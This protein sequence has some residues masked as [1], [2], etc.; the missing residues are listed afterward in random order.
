MDCQGELVGYAGEPGDYERE[1]V[2][3]AGEPEEHEGEQGTAIKLVLHSK[4]HHR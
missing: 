2:G 4:P 3:Y 1:L